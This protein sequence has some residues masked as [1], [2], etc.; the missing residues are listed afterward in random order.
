MRFIKLKE[1]ICSP[2]T[3]PLSQSGGWGSWSTNHLGNKGDTISSWDVDKDD[4]SHMGSCWQQVWYI[5]GYQKGEREREVEKRKNGERL[6]S[7]EW[8]CFLQVTAQVFWLKCA[9][10]PHPWSSYPIE[11]WTGMPPHP[12]SSFSNP[13]SSMAGGS[14]FSSFSSSS[15][16]YWAIIYR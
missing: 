12:L 14:S 8:N 6:K 5:G 4:R 3:M 16:L 9:C 7:F 1:V 10:L 15:Y 2:Q 13:N 11:H